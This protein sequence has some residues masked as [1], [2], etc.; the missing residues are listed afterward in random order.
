MDIQAQIDAVAAADPGMAVLLENRR[1][2][3][4][5]IEHAEM[6]SRQLSVPGVGV[7]TELSDA[8]RRVGG[9]TTPPLRQSPPQPPPQPPP[10]RLPQPPPQVG[11]TGTPPGG[12]A[13]PQP[14]PQ[15]VGG[16]TT[17]P[18][19]QPPPQLQIG[20]FVQGFMG[21][22]PLGDATGFDP[23]FGF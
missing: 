13:T 11:G 9:T 15:V 6:L 19:P 16:A 22:E 10:R 4:S 12:M 5:L 8:S 14:P 23:Q 21:G 20:Q 1:L 17:P 2:A 3:R 7:A 18:L